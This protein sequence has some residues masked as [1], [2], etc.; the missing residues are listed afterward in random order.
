[1]V[2]GQLPNLLEGDHVD[3]LFLTLCS[4]SWEHFLLTDLSVSQRI[5]LSKIDRTPAAFCYIQKGRY[6][7]RAHRKERS[8]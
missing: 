3:R 4:R 1:M 6:M 8:R 2:Q 5:R 7:I